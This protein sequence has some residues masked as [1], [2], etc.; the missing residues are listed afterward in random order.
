MG[1]GLGDDERV[2][3]GEDVGLGGEG[4]AEEPGEEEEAP[5]GEA[6]VGATGLGETGGEGGVNVGLGKGCRVKGPAGGGEAPV[7]AEAGDD[8]VVGEH[9]VED[10][11]K[12]V[13]DGGEGGG[14]EVV[15]GL[16]LEGHDAAGGK[17]VADYGEEALGEEEGGGVAFHGVG[18]VYEDDVEGEVSVLE[19][20]FG[21]LVEEGGAG[22]VEGAGVPSGEVSTGGLD[23]LLINVDH[24][25]LLD[26]FVI[27]GVPEGCTL[28]AASDED[29]SRGW[30]G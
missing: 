13:A 12:G 15:H 1:G 10:L 2:G 24:D 11:G 4:L 14:A 5:V 20:V 3:F 28:A 18:E 30:G 16:G 7:S 25:G 29:A 26:A 19:V 21:V 17:P 27:Q 9:L 23:Y 8:D 22:V 6:V